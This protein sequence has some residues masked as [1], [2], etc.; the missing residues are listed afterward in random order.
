M[1]SSPILLSSSDDPGRSQAV[2]HPFANVLDVVCGVDVLLGTGTITIRNC[3]KLQRLSV[4]R[5]EQT[6]GSDMDVQVHGVSV[7]LGEAMIVDE[8]TAVRISSVKPPV[9]SGAR[10]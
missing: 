9:G 8:S 1:S 10:P 7:A 4:I 5:L 3:L 2:P 6:A